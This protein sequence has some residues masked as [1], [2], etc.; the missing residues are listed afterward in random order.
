MASIADRLKAAKG[1]GGSSGGGGKQASSLSGSVGESAWEDAPTSFDRKCVMMEIYGDTGTGRTRLALTAP[2]PIALAHAAE[3]VAGEIQRAIKNGKK[4]KIHNFGCVLSGE[5]QDIA[6]Q[7]RPVWKELRSRWIGAN[8]WAKTRVMD[9]SSEGWEL[10]RLAVFGTVTP[11]GR[12]ENLYGPV[13]AEWRGMFKSH[14]SQ[15]KVNTIFIHQTKDEYI[16]KKTPKGTNSER[17]GETIRVAM[18]EMPFIA[19]VIVRTSK[20]G[21]KFYATIEKGWHNAD[22]EGTEFE[23]ED[24]TFENIMSV[25]EPSVDWSK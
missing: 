15:N 24:A 12:T 14:G 4:L 18:K 6:N 1:G 11:Q 21:G 7:A 23:G 10:K 8:G 17:T 20:H 16:T 13:N 19:E 2:G 3:K 22:T 9:T 5:P 25:I